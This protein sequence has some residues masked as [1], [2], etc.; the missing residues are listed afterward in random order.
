[1]VTT[2]STDD[3]DTTVA[4]VDEIQRDAEVWFDD[5]NVVVVAEHSAFR[6]HKSILSSHS[7]VFK[8]LFAVPQPPSLPSESTCPV[9][10][11]SDSSQDCRELLRAIYGGVNSF[12]HPAKGRAIPFPTL[13]AL[14]RLS[15][16]YQLDDLLEA[17]V[18][19]LQAVFTT[20]FK[21][22]PARDN[23]RSEIMPQVGDC[24]VEA[25]NLVRLLGRTDMLPTAI[26]CC[27]LLEPE[28]LVLGTARSDGTLEKLT[29]GDLILCLHAQKALRDKHIE[30][31]LCYLAEEASPSDNCFNR[32]KCTEA[33]K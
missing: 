28:D 31:T 21:L 20:E 7:V 6:C 33:I 11:V 4:A 12:L 25:L 5:G 18:C 22:W 16:K 3:S 9:V 8:D 15:H 10:R 26:Y 32:D 13:A 1:M 19:R 14:A 27:C 23:L 2:A 29:T 24:A 30:L 17:V